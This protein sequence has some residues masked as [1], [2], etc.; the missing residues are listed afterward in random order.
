[1]R[2]TDVARMRGGGVKAIWP[3]AHVGSCLPACSRTM[4]S[5]TSLASRIVCADALLVLAVCGRRA[6]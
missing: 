2:T 5:A 4:Y 6:P 1:M 3:P